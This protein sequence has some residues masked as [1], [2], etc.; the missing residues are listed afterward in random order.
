M[1]IENLHLLSLQSTSEIIK[2]TLGYR[3]VEK[4][5]LA[6]YQHFVELLTNSSVAMDTMRTLAKDMGHP[7]TNTTTQETSGGGLRY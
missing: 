6:S 2:R 3:L 4:T 7:P 5:Y 1:L